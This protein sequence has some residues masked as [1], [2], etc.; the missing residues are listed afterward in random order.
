MTRS[1]WGVIFTLNSDQLGCDLLGLFDQLIDPHTYLFGGFVFISF[2]AGG[3]RIHGR[4]GSLDSILFDSRG[5]GVIDYKVIINLP[6]L[7]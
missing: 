4:D 3:V 7:V 6:K 2:D 1:R 5:I